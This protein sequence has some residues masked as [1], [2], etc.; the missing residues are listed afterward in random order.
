MNEINTPVQAHSAEE[1]VAHCGGCS[2]IDWEHDELDY[3]SAGTA[4]SLRARVVQE[5]QR[6][7]IPVGIP[8][9]NVSEDYRVTWI[10]LLRK[11]NRRK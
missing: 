5:K 9:P 10:Q 11:P 4:D 6:G 3:V 1:C 7:Y 8:Y 2:Q